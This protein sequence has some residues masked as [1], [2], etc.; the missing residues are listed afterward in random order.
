MLKLLFLQ[1]I[2]QKTYSQFKKFAKNYTSDGYILN[3]E[4]FTIYIKN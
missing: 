1:F 2:F 3:S 4:L